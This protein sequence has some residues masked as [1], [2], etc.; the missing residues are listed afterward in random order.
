MSVL[1][2]TTALHSKTWRTI[3]VNHKWSRAKQLYN[4]DSETINCLEED[5]PET[6]EKILIILCSH[7]ET[8][9]SA[10]EGLKFNQKLLV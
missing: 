3:S 2:N 4:T 10:N 9:I 8:F 1:T 5:N 6:A 7:N